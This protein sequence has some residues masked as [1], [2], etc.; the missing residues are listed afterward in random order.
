M[1]NQP[2]VPNDEFQDPLED[3]EPPEYGDPLERAL[4]EEKVAVIESRP[5]ETISPDLPVS[6]ALGKLADMHH[7]CL[8]VAEDDQL[9]GLFTDRD[10]LNRVALDYDAMKDEPVSSVMRTDPVY[11]L[12]SDSAAAA[13][14]VMA[15]SGYRHVPVLTSDKNVAGII[16]PQRVTEFLQQRMHDGD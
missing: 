2:E 6:A 16:S 4:A 11:V 12:E 3:Y 5:F 1:T 10:V 15:V 13:L 7:A 14:A 8:L 9:V